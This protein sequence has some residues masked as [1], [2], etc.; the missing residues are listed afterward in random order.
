MWKENLYRPVITKSGVPEIEAAFDHL[1]II[2]QAIQS[3]LHVRDGFSVLGL[4]PPISR[5]P[6]FNPAQ[7]LPMLAENAPQSRRIGPDRLEMFENEIDWLIAHSGGS[8]GNAPGGMEGSRYRT[9]ILTGPRPPRQAAS[10]GRDHA[11]GLS[12]RIDVYK[13]THE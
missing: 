6:D 12:W 5:D 10:A 8:A 3:D 9:K 4:I 13:Y 2:P 1:D 11:A 7:P